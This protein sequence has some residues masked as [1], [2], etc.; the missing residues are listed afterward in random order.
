MSQFWIVCE[1]VFHF[2][3]IASIQN[4]WFHFYLDFI[5][6]MNNLNSKA[7]IFEWTDADKL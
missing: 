6:S 1:N 5:E 3:I 2:Y 7:V 4:H